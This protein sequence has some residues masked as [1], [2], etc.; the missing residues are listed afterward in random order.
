MIP[1]CSTG[2]RNLCFNQEI[3]KEEALEKAIKEMGLR[4]TNTPGVYCEQHN[5]NMPKGVY[6]N[7]RH[8]VWN[9]GTQ[10]MEELPGIYYINA[11]GADK[12][13]SCIKN[14]TLQAIL[15]GY[16][17]TEQEGVYSKNSKNYE[18]NAQTNKFEEIVTTS[19]NITTNTTDVIGS[20]ADQ[21]EAFENE[22]EISEPKKLPTPEVAREERRDWIDGWYII[23]QE[24]ADGNSIRSIFYDANGNVQQIWEYERYSDGSTIQKITSSDGSYSLTKF[25]DGSRIGSY[26]EYDKEGNLKIT[27]KYYNYAPDGSSYY[28]ISEYSDGTILREEVD[29]INNYSMIDKTYADGT[30]EINTNFSDIEINIEMN[31]DGEIV[32]IHMYSLE[33]NNGFGISTIS[34][35]DFPK[36]MQQLNKYIE[37]INTQL[38]EMRPVHPNVDN[39][40]NSDEA[41]KEWDAFFDAL[42]QYDIETNEIYSELRE[43][44]TRKNEYM[45]QQVAVEF[46]RKVIEI[47][48]TIEELR[49]NGK[50]SKADEIQVQL[51]NQIHEFA[52]NFVNTSVARRENKDDICSVHIPYPPHRK[53]YRDENGNVNEVEYDK[54]MQEYYDLLDEYNKKCEEINQK[55]KQCFQLDNEL[56]EGLL[57]VNSLAGNV[58]IYNGT[59]YSGTPLRLLYGSDGRYSI[60]IRENGPYG[61]EYRNVEGRIKYTNGIPTEVVLNDGS[62]VR[63]KA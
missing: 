59:T 12:N 4:K 44:E 37:N 8:Y 53:D 5:P 7:Q 63:L 40:T 13:G 60:Q 52:S 57:S 34:E 39:I 42:A 16:E 36:I 15:Q 1:V 62:T 38:T 22:G 6:T 33:L 58:T 31:K 32:N 51:N 45:N 27:T 56:M 24:D 10:Q 28:S 29:R 61:Y 41:E 30:R 23:D 3:S 26:E 17:C 55:E 2:T 25:I 14:A 50:D 48:K 21:L 20:I 11:K 54:A 47:E 19:N 18:Y 49:K 9:S 43:F 35:E 46:F